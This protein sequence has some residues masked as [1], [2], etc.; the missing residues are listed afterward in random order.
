[1][2][3]RKE[4][5]IQ[6]VVKLHELTP[7]KYLHSESNVVVTTRVMCHTLSRNYDENVLVVTARFALSFLM[8][9]NVVIMAQLRA[10]LFFSFG[11]GNLL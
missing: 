9:Q 11:Q 3:C 6:E 7:L 2:K 5:D 10:Y 4:R 8:T 1:M